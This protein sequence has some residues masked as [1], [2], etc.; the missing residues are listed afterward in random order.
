MARLL[1][2]RVPACGPKTALISSR[3]SRRN[4][5]GFIAFDGFYSPSVVIVQQVAALRARI[6][7]LLTN[8]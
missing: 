4:G 3:E 1:E 8:G 5:S 2:R 7:A 6:G